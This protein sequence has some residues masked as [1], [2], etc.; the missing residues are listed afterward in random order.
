VLHVVYVAIAHFA[1]F[2]HYATVMI[3]VMQAPSSKQHK[4]NSKHGSSSNGRD[5]W[6]DTLYG[7]DNN[8]NDNESVVL[9]INHNYLA[10][11]EE[12]LSNVFGET[13]VT[14]KCNYLMFTNLNY[15]LVLN[16]MLLAC[17]VLLSL[18]MFTLSLLLIL[19]TIWLI[20]RCYLYIQ[21]LSCIT[22]LQQSVASIKQ[23]M[24]TWHVHLRSHSG[25]YLELL[26]CIR[27]YCNSIHLRHTAMLFLYVNV[28]PLHVPIVLVT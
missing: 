6:G 15:I 22:Q 23:L 18:N 5:S 1:F 20:R 10:M 27:V 9:W 4:S 26:Y 13:A 8:S 3:D 19:F 14:G 24:V 17:I 25:T 16:V 21:C 11:A 28:M 2:T 7:S 12:V